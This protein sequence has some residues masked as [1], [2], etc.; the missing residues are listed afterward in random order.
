MRM[1]TSGGSIFIR[2]TSLHYAGAARM[3]DQEWHSAGDPRLRLMAHA[4]RHEQQGEIALMHGVGGAEARRQAA[5]NML[6]NNL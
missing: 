2:L 1:T 6:A 5:R 3:M 4:M